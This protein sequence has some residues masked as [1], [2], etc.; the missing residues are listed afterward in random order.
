MA[1]TKLTQDTLVDVT[2]TSTGSVGYT[3]EQSTVMR[4]WEKQNVS[5]KVKLGELRE[6]VGTTGGYVLFAENILLIRDEKIREELNLP[7]LDKYTL[8]IPEIKDLLHNKPLDE[9]VDMVEN[10]TQD[11]LDSITNVAIET[12]ISDFNKIKTIEEYTGAD[13]VSA[14]KEKS[15]KEEVKTVE[16]APTKRKPRNKKAE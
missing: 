1:V 16:K 14:I 15:E 9:L 12:S 6:V 11:Q 7:E 8:T 13:V 3:P 2:N 5:K 10:C 4:K